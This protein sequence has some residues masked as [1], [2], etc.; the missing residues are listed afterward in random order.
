M[1]WGCIPILIFWNATWLVVD[2]FQAFSLDNKTSDQALHVFGSLFRLR[3]MYQL[4]VLF[5]TADYNSHR[6]LTILPKLDD[7]IIEFPSDDDGAPKWKSALQHWW[8][9]LGVVS[10]VVGCL[11]ILLPWADGVSESTLP[12][13]KLA[14]YCWAFILIGAGAGCVACGLLWW[15]RPSRTRS[16]EGR[17]FLDHNG[18]LF[19][20]C[21]TLTLCN[22]FYNGGHLNKDETGWQWVATVLNAIEGTWQFFVLGR[23]TSNVRV[24]MRFRGTSGAVLYLLLHNL[25]FIIW[26]VGSPLASP[27]VGNDFLSYCL[28]TATAN[29]R[30]MAFTYLLVFLITSKHF[31]CGPTVEQ[32]R[33]DLEKSRSNVAA[34][35]SLGRIQGY[36]SQ[37]VH[38]GGEGKRAFGNG[39]RKSAQ[40]DLH[41]ESKEEKKVEVKASEQSPLLNG[42]G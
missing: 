17:E 1:F 37:A 28:R 25:G 9:C 11:G 36:G 39:D 2:L 42:G 24:C 7:T 5:A 15:L 26:N 8:G 34:L 32:A 30:L 33:S 13:F 23:I 14:V 19:V 41:G 12:S 21:G 35:G 10:V 4:V 40:P 16:R 20:L 6:K 22:Y 31:Q 27:S 18:P 3:T 29:Y 38:G